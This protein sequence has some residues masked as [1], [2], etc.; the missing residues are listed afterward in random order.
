M[1]YIEWSMK[2]YR[3]LI[4][5]KTTK[6]YKNMIA[7]NLYKNGLSN[8]Q[9][10]EKLSCRHLDLNRWLTVLKDG[11]EKEEMETYDIMEE[12]YG[13]YYKDDINKIK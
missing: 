12:V 1:K 11:T 13:Y 4:N 7:C 6:R 5:P 3:F 8:A 9:I 10:K 2:E